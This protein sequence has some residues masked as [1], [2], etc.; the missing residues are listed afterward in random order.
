MNKLAKIKLTLQ[1]QLFDELCKAFT[2][3]KSFVEIRDNIE[4]L[5]SMVEMVYYGLMYKRSHDS[6]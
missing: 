3:H 1:Q 6:N 2:D 5:V 4:F